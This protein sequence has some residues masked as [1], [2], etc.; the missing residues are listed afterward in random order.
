VKEFTSKVDKYFNFI[1]QSNKG[2][3]EN[4]ILA[5]LPPSLKA[6]LNFIRYNE[7]II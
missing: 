4:K 3:D 2:L 6:E 5:D 1:W 7:A